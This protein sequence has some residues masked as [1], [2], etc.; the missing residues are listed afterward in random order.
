MY[1]HLKVRNSN[2]LPSLPNSQTDSQTDTQTDSQTHSNVLIH[3]VIDKCTSH[4]AY[5][6][7]YKVVKRKLS[8]HKKL[9]AK[10]VY[11]VFS[12]IL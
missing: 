8:T 4:F 3:C 1:L 6:N 12:I 5:D 2:K 11:N 7:Y 10:T 9:K